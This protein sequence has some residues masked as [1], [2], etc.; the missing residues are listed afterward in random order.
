MSILPEL[1][2]VV[3][4]VIFVWVLYKAYLPDL[5]PSVEAKKEPVVETEP[6]LLYTKFNIVKLEVT[7][8]V[9]ERGIRLPDN[10]NVVF[11][12]G[13]KILLFLNQ[14][15]WGCPYGCG[16]DKK[17]NRNEPEPELPKKCSMMRCT[18][19]GS[20]LKK[21]TSVLD[22]KFHTFLCPTHGKEGVILG[23]WEADAERDKT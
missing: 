2:G 4:A 5:G 21:Y 17:A 7:P 11:E 12:C 22:P 14:T 9:T 16:I 3:S 1:L 8:I 10:A 18:V 15:Y 23:I 19:E 20:E 6:D 13:H